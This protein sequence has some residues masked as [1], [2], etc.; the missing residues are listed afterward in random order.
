MKIKFVVHNQY[1]ST[2]SLEKASQS[3][4]KMTLH[5]VTKNSSG[6]K[7]NNYL[8]LFPAKYQALLPDKLPHYSNHQVIR[9]AFPPQI[10]GCLHFLVG[11]LTE[12]RIPWNALKSYD[13]LLAEA[14]LNQCYLKSYTLVVIV[15]P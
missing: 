4:V 10:F 5:I 2:W 8:F 15:I 14:K 9:N 1:I 13:G 7:N 12:Q 6:G 3:F 11:R